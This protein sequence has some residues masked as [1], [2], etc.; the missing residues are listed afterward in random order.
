MLIWSTMPHDRQENS[1]TKLVGMLIVYNEVDIIEQYL[2]HMATQEIPLVVLDGGSTDGTYGIIRENRTGIVS[3]HAQFITDRFELVLSLRCLHAMAAQ[4]NPDWMLLA[5]ADEFMETN[6]PKLSLREAIALEDAKGFNLI[7]FD[8]YEF[9]PTALDPPVRDIRE[10]IRYYSWHDRWRFR[11][12][13]HGP[14][15]RIHPS[16]GHLP[17]FPENMVVRLSPNRFIIRHYSIRDYEQ[18]RRKAFV[19]RLGRYSDFDRRIFGLRRYESYK[20]EKPFFVIE[21]RMLNRFDGKWNN[22][23]KFAGWR[24]ETFPDLSSSEEVRRMMTEL[25]KNYARSCVE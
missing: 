25:A 10:R 16:G 19:E 17:I 18:G 14:G 24:T 11:A 4:E 6:D 20:D 23:R 13:K 1:A 21:P 3:R 7:Q 2:D 22:E 12:W 15:I 5:D 8:N 9:W